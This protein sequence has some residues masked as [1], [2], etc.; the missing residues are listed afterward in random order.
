MR[1]RASRPTLAIVLTTALALLLWACAPGERTPPPATDGDVAVGVTVIGPGRVT[2]TFADADAPFDCRGD[3]TWHGDDGALTSITAMPSPGNVFVAWSGA[4]DALPNPCS[5][6]FEDGDTVTATFAPHA[7]RLELIGD[8]TGVFRVQGGGVSATCGASCG[9][10]LASPLSVALTYDPEGTTGTVLG[11]WSG[12][13]AAAALP[14][15]CVVSVSGATEVGKVW[16]HPPT[17]FDDAFGTYRN[18]RLVVAAPGV[19]ANDVDTPDDTLTA[20]LVSGV[21]HGVLTL[22]AD[23]G[24]EYLPAAG[25]IGGDGFVY[26]V[27]DAFGSTDTANVTID[28]VNRAPAAR[29]IAFEGERGRPLVVPAPGVLENDTDPDGDTLTAELVSGVSHGTLDLAADGGFTYTPSTTYVDADAFTYR[30]SDGD[31]ESE[32]ATVTFTL[33][34]VNRPPVANDVQ[35]ETD[36]DEPLDVPAPGVLANDTD[37]DGDPLTAV[38][39][40]GVAHGTLD[41]AADGGFRYVP[42]KGFDGTDAFTYRASDGDLESEPATVTIKVKAPKPGRPGKP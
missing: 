26:R 6:E 19:L 36:R 38:L 24:F 12:A 30:A 33:R 8:G 11:D 5:R 21:S 2:A 42:E 15:Y 39:E 13:C 25:Y 17:A 1:L 32:P 14:N 35:Y 34:A 18:T 7:L 16:R 41:L 31:L 37:P 10:S 9:V 20:E 4:C 40:D 29:D 27:R 28:V 22:A 3:C 23:G